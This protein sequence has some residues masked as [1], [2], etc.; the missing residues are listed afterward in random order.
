MLAYGREVEGRLAE[1][2]SSDTAIAETEQQRQDAA[3]QYEA[4]AKSLSER[5]RK[6]AVKY[7]LTLVRTSA[8]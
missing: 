4:L 1:L 3:Q 6:A 5:R 8:M 7:I 2:E